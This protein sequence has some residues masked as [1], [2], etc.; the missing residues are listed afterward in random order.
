MITAGVPAD[1]VR[2]VHVAGSAEWGGGE[3]YLELLARHL[4]RDRFALEIV[5]PDPGPFAECLRELGVPFQVVDLT[6]LVSPAAILRLTR[7]LR[8]RRPHIVQSH[9]ARSN[10]YARL[11][12]TLLPG[13]RHISTVHN[14]LLAYPVSPLRRAVYRSLDRL[15]RPL[16]ARVLSVARALTD[17]DHGRTTVIPNG[18]EL[19][20]FNPT[21]DGEPALRRAL[22]LG[23]GPVVGFAGRLDPQKDPLTFVRVIAR[24]REELPAVN[25]LVVGDGPLRD[26]V[27]QE[28][29]RLGLTDHCRFTGFRSDVPALLGAMDLFLLSSISEGFPFVLLEAMAM[30]L[31]VV[32]TAVSGVLEI[33]EPGV[34]GVLVAPGDVEGLA[35]AAF[36]VLQHPERARALGNAARQRVA[37]RF[38]IQRMIE[39][40]EHLYLEVASRAGG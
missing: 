22:G 26:E 1:L 24:L 8:S 19:N 21:T 37:A 30:A 2:I 4:D 39:A 10:F 14:S 16:S 40:T 36:D 13:V 18:V 38:S 32:A 35:A 23:D 27:T 12:V 3:R 34:S 6:R 20:V 7:V 11:A 9:G 33:V 29:A 17:E 15:T 5:L 31:P 28:A 25:A